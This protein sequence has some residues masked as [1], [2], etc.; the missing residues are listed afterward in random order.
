MQFVIIAEH[1]PE[2]CPMSNAKIR[3]LM[4]ES[5]TEIPS[6][7]ENAA[8]AQAAELRN[9][10][11]RAGP[12][13]PILSTGAGVAAARRTRSTRPRRPSARPA[14]RPWD[15][16]QAESNGSRR[17]TGTVTAAAPGNRGPGKQPDV[18]EGAEPYHVH[19]RFPLPL[20]TRPNLSSGKWEP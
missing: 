14:T 1:S 20:R 2:L 4:K 8:L 19:Q 6:Q 9:P 5:A 10:R 17:R 15:T 18:A 3:D 16:E 13:M 7:A 12:H 11:G